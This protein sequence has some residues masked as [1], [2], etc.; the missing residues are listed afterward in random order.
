MCK[1]KEEGE[2][3]EHSKNCRWFKWM[4]YKANSVEVICL[5]GLVRAGTKVL[6]D[7]ACYRK[8]FGLH[9]D[10]ESLKSLGRVATVLK[11]N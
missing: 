3:K 9:N 10:G 4:G 2:S 8:D 11:T 1:G 7:H 5:L 6:G